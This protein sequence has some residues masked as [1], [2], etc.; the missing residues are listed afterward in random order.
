VIGAIHPI[1]P[2]TAAS[3]LAFALFAKKGTF[4]MTGFAG[5]TATAKSEAIE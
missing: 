5:P 1:L 3:F 2:G 4:R